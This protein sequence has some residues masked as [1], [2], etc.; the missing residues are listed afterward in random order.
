MA[1]MLRF[2]EAWD[3]AI[4]IDAESKNA[5]IILGNGF[6]IGA[7]PEFNYGRLYEVAKSRGIP[8]RAEQLFD[9]YGTNNFELVL[10]QLHESAWLA[11]RYGLNASQIQE[12]HEAVKT[13]L[14]DAIATVHPDNLSILDYEEIERIGNFLRHFRTVATTNYDL[15]LYWVL[16]V[17]MEEIR[18]N[19]RSFQDGFG[20]PRGAAGGELHFF[21]VPP[22]AARTVCYLHGGLHL[23]RIQGTVQKRRWG[24]DG[25]LIAQARSAISND[26]PPLFVSE[27]R[28]ENK[29][30]QI[31]ANGYLSWAFHQLRNLEGTVVAYGWSVPDQDGHLTRAI[32]ANRDISTL[33]IGMYDDPNSSAGMELQARGRKLEER[34]KLL[35]RRGTKQ[36]PGL[37]VQYFDSNSLEMWSM[38]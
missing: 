29:E 4:Q 26:E 13:A 30:A 22:T 16:N 32:C 9:R 20:Y 10:N 27:G 1:E 14:I 37:S 12:D 18:K 6:S 24:F 38:R 5:H 8:Y 23:A 19:R 33:W 7:H 17:Y 2:D 15:I 34:S 31:Q 36:L 21:G 25:S 28:K 35:R 11:E 3:Q